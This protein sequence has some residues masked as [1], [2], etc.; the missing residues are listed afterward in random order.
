MNRSSGTKTGP[1]AGRGK[2]GNPS[3]E[4]SRPSDY[5]QQVIDFL[6]DEHDAVKTLFEDGE[7]FADDSS[8][9]QAIV[10]QAC[11]ALTR[12]AQLEE[13]FFYPALGEAGADLIAQAQVEHDCAKQLIADLESMDADDERYHA[14][15]KVL[16]E[17]VKH[18]IAEEE[19][20]IFPLARESGRDFEPAF[21]ALSAQGDG[22]GGIGGDA[23][24]D[25]DA[26]SSRRSRGSPQT[27][28]PRSRR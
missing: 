1:A 19:G 13:E 23:S 11:E 5:V 3:D 28:T 24:D 2:T 16:G 22:D 14:T 15:F 6:T 25:A 10:E 4:L 9:L 12:H 21:E 7:K 17:Y 18:H 8:R 20:E 26:T 27:S